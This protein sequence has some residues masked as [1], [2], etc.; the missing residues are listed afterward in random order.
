MESTSQ[1]HKIDERYVWALILC[2]GSPF[3][4]LFQGLNIL[5][6]C[7]FVLYWINNYKYYPQ[8][9]TLFL[10]LL[11]ILGIS[12]IQTY[13]FCWNSFPAIVNFCCK[14]FWGGS[15]YLILGNRFRQ[16]YFKII[17]ILAFLSLIF[18]V[19]RLF[20]IVFPGITCGRANCIIFYNYITEWQGGLSYRNCGFPWEP[21][22]FGCYL[23]FAFIL[24]IDSLPKLWNSKRMSCLFII[25]AILSTMS[26]TAYI[27]IAVIGC[28]VLLLKVK[29]TIVKYTWVTIILL[30]CFYIGKNLSFLSSKIVEQSESAVKSN[31][32]FN[33]TRLGSLLFD[34]YYIQKHPL[35]GNGLN[36]RTRYADHQYLVKL[37][38]SGREAQSGNGF[39]SIIAN[40]GLLFL[41]LYFYIFNRRN[42][43]SLSF[44]TRA[45]IALSIILLLFG[46]PLLNYPFL[47]G[48]PLVRIP[49]D[50]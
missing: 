35:V 40:M 9:N 29:R 27:A 42:R 23:M 7:L 10:Y 21:G 16:V 2:S 24:Y 5:F 37:W 11:G 6:S 31:G 28:S 15:I 18:W 34:I 38:E 30:G 8:L 50:L 14:V 47:L 1:L 20:N 32:K 25:M 22:A 49:N 45:I 43:K 4:S 13:I 33:S 26:T 41:I 17:T 44:D 12:C 46:E 3:F 19:L 36:S 48:F 39:S